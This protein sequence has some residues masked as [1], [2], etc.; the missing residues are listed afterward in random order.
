MENLNK[1]WLYRFA[2]LGVAVIV[3]ICFLLLLAIWHEIETIIPSIHRKRQ[4]KHRFKKK[5]LAKC[6]CKDCKYYFSANKNVSDEG[7]CHNHYGWHVADNWFCWDAT[8]DKK[9]EH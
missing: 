7:E 1:E 6:Y 2:L 8:P 4:Y 3:F 9:K 5:P